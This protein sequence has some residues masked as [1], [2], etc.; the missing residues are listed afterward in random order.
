MTVP[1]GEKD[2]AVN[3]SGMTVMVDGRVVARRGGGGIVA[4]GVEEL[5]RKRIEKG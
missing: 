5:L 1:K 4:V 3:G 2:S